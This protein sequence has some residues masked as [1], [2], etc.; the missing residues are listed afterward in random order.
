M[1]VKITI[2]S[3]TLMNKGLELIEAYHLFALDPGEI[4]VL[5]H[6]QSIVHG[7]VEFRDGSMIAQLGVHDMRIPIAHCLAWPARIQGPAARLNLATIANLSFEQPDLDRFP[8][9]AV[10]R[11]ALAA[12]GAAPT[13]LN[14]ANEVA[15]HEFAGHRLG[16]TGIPALVE[17]TL[18]AVERAGITAEPESL[19]EA[20]A[21]D[22]AGR[23][24]AAALLPE[25][26]AKIS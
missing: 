1:G 5:V 6:P 9:L 22:Q 3:A 8:A 15:V 13:V 19:E 23:S 21:I 11:R 16:F 10:A 24:A 17:A 7:L 12:G 18:E 14:A 26:A 2:D 20:I 4:D 25:I